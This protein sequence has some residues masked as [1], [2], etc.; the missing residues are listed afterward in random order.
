M[1]RGSSMNGLFCGRPRMLIA[2]LGNILFGDDGVGVHAVRHFQNSAPR[3]CLAAEIGTDLLC[4][5]PLFESYDRIIVFDAFQAGGKPGS[6][7]T[8]RAEEILEKCERD[9]ARDSELARAL[10]SLSAE[11]VI[12]AAEPGRMEWGVELSPAVESAVHVMIREARRIIA[13]W[14]TV[15]A[16]WERIGLLPPANI[17]EAKI[18]VA[19]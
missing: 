15:D 8:F 11:V 19:G 4:A 18:R 13:E 16:Q 6:V 2:G 7:Y 10:G 5:V 9:S 14:Q 17:K 12:I 1:D 3:T